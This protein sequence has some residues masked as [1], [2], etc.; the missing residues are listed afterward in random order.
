MKG[1]FK[2]TSR[3][4]SSSKQ[5][6]PQKGYLLLSLFFVVQTGIL[7]FFGRS[8]YLPVTASFLTKDPLLS[9]SGKVVMTSATRTVFNVNILY[10]LSLLLIFMAVYYLVIG[11]FLQA[12]YLNSITSKLSKYKWVNIGVSTT[13]VMII[14]C[15][16]LGVFDLGSIVMIMALIS[17]L[18][19]TGY[20][21]ERLKSTD[22]SSSRLSFILGSSALTVVWV[23]F[24]Y[25]IWNSAVIGGGG[26]EWY[27]YLT[28][29][30]ALLLTYMQQ[31]SL[32]TYC[33]S[34][35]GKWADYSYIEKI[36][37][38]LSIVLVMAV[39]WITFFGI[40]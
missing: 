33:M 2:K 6:K 17:T 14:L 3:P 20:L 13:L 29:L 32:R 31:L 5:D 40:R 19:V 26:L 35:K 27:A 25:Y 30:I 15:M 7:L 23:V 9:N 22:Q 21:A 16:L 37:Q 39:V 34:S 4:K 8:D 12:K 36:N 18:S 10:I 38:K 24:A 28:A 11:N 1:K